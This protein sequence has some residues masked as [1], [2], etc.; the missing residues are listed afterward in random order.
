[1]HNAHIHCAPLF[2]RYKCVGTFVTHDTT[3]FPIRTNVIKRILPIGCN[4][5]PTLLLLW[6]CTIRV[7]PFAIIP[8]AFHFTLFS[9][10]FTTISFVLNAPRVIVHGVIFM[11]HHFL[12]TRGL[13]SLLQV[14]RWLTMPLVFHMLQTS[15]NRRQMCPWYK[16]HVL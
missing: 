6:C 8:F 11:W 13:C 10:F 2:S 12:C 5:C 7:S 14:Q 9:L 1:M 3:W 4:A 15:F 16:L